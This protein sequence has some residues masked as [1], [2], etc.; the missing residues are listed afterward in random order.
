MRHAVPRCAI[1]TIAAAL[2][3]FGQLH[4]QDE[5]RALWVVRTTL[6]SPSAIATMVTAA[7]SGGFNTLLVQVRGRNTLGWE[8]KFEW[9]VRYV[10][11]RS[12]WLDL[13]IL[14]LTVKAVLF[15][16]G[17]NAQGDATMPEFNPSST[18]GPASPPVRH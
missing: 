15:R 16:E 8:E 17:I 4:A 2:L 1:A 9:D 14:F 7:K 18:A 11:T 12:F 13:Q 10:E 3:L 6:T 5:V